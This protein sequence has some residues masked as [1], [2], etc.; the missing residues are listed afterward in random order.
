MAKT[1]SL[2]SKSEFPKFD[3]IFKHITKLNHQMVEVFKRGDSLEIAKFYSDDGLILSYR[4]N[5]IQGRKAFD[6]Y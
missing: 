5:R 1:V 2:F 4:G 6:D 3:A